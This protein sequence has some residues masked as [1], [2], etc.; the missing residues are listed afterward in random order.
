MTEL[1]VKIREDARFSRLYR[2]REHD[3]AIARRAQARFRRLTGQII[4]GTAAASVAGGLVLYGMEA[5]PDESRWL[6]DKLART[7]TR[8][9]LLIVQGGFLALAAYA[10]YVLGERRPGERW[11]VHRLRAEDGRLELARRALKIGHELGP[12]VFRQVGEWF[13]SFVEGQRDHLRDATDRR[14]RAAES[15]AVLGAV[16][17]GVLALAGA[18]AGIR[19][20]V[21]VVFIAILG[22]CSPALVAAI[23]SWRGAVQDQK[24][25]AL[26]DSSWRALNQLGEREPEFQAAI[27]ASDFDSAMAYVEEIF[28]VLRKD[29]AGFASIQ[30]QMIDERTPERDLR[31]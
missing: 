12:N 16:L 28:S 3:A 25:A 15:L 11:V 2:L 26:H 22:V 1:P 31:L 4:L 14:D 6:V 30:D 10:G 27:D 20:E 17:T 9:A 7:D 24:R 23:Q 8:T 21:V 29:H 19:Q 18:I 5:E 13:I